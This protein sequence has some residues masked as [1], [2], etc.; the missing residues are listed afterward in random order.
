[1]KH[2][3]L[4]G[5]HLWGTLVWPIIKVKGYGCMILAASIFKSQGSYVRSLCLNSKFRGTE[6]SG[7]VRS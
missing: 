3:L 1:M 7:V 4:D 6:K 5:K 2:S